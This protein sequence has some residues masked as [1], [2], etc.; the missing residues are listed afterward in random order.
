MKPA[1]KLYIFPI[2]VNINFCLQQKMWHNTDSQHNN[3]RY[4]LTQQQVSVTDELHY[5]VHAQH[6]LA[7]VQFVQKN[8]SLSPGGG[9]VYR[10]FSSFAAMWGAVVGTF[11]D[12]FT[13]TMKTEVKVNTPT[14]QEIH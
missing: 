4:I 3:Q 14:E 1:R 12:G 11:Q 8:I 9:G 7:K 6:W 5:T 2:L 10:N 13:A